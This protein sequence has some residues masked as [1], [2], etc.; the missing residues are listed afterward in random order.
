[1]LGLEMEDYTFKQS[2]P[3]YWPP[4]KLHL[5]RQDQLLLNFHFLNLACLLIKPDN[6]NLTTATRQTYPA[7]LNASSAGE[8]YMTGITGADSRVSL[9]LYCVMPSC[10]YVSAGALDSI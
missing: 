8:A 6:S 3:V 2:Q 5:I 1:M 9:R 10:R 7:G 4:V